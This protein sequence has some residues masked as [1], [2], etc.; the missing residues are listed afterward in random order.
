FIVKTYKQPALVEEFISGQ[1]FTVAIVGNENPEVMPV[2]QI[3]IDG[4]LKLNDK[5][6]TFARI[7]S[8]RL[9][10]ICPAKI[11]NEL[12]KK[13]DAL[14]LKVYR[15][16]ECRDFGRVDFRVDNNGNPYV[17]EINPLPSLSTEDV[18]MLVAKN[19]GITYEQMVGKILNS[20]IARNGLN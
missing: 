7:T 16:V 1:E 3:K 6:Y 5:F 18:F 11:H 8:D 19:I 14:A 9:E 2:V 12:K 10:Y 17:L 13:L 15:G 20:A 4:R